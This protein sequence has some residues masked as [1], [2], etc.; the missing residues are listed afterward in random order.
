MPCLQGTTN[1]FTYLKGGFISGGQ[2]KS[3]INKICKLCN[4]SFPTRLRARKYCKTCKKLVDAKRKTMSKETKKPMTA[5]EIRKQLKAAS[6]P[7]AKREGA[8][9]SAFG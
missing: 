9:A 2:A 1:T 5:A 3:C 7:V 4:N 6:S 8:E